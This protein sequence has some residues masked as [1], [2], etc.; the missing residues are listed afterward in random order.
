[1]IV[2]RSVL[3][4]LLLM[5]G[6][7]GVTS[8]AGGDADAESRADSSSPSGRSDG[9]RGA[10][11]AETDASDAT[12]DAGIDAPTHTPEAGVDGSTS[13]PD[14][15]A[16]TGNPG[17]DAVADAVASSDGGT[18][19][20]AADGCAFACGGKCV[21][22]ETDVNN[23]GACGTVCLVLCSRGQCAVVTA[24]SA[25]LGSACGL[26]SG[27]AVECW[28]D[29]YGGALGTGSSTAPD[30]CPDGPCSSTPVA[31]TGVTNATS[32]SLGI[33]SGCALL[34]DGTVDCWGDNVDGQ[35]GSGSTT[36]PDDC[37]GFACGP[38]PA[39]VAG[40]SGVSALSFGGSGGCARLSGGAVQCWGL[41][42]SGELGVG[43][44]TG[45]EAC[46]A[47]ET[48]SPTPVVVPALTGVTT[49]AIGVVSSC[50]L[51]SDGTVECWGSNIF[52]QLGSGTATGPELCGGEPCS[53]TPVP[54]AGLAGVTAVSVGWLSA[55]AV[56]SDGTVDCWGAS[57][58][59]AGPETCS[60]LACSTTPV[61]VSGLSG[62]T[63]VSVG[64][65]SA[66]AV[67]SDGTVDCWGENEFGQ[68]G[69]GGTVTSSSPLPVTGLADVSSVSVGLHFTACAV[70]SGGNVKCWG[71][72][73]F[74]QLGNG[75]ITGPDSCG[76][77]GCSMTPVAVLW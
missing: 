62:V 12:R 75:T 43:D 14:A 27:G 52:G 25:G 35:L 24:V 17:P 1:M 11:A 66:C 16:S 45:P 70:V 65:G 74:G 13:K 46:A 28:G 37:G 10:P 29:N 51:L 63:S 6:C 50:A 67:L 3:A 53:T 76:G 58:G 64:M 68:L 33:S 72:N 61:P 2:K 5:T 60:G 32:V 20:S 19:G 36:G 73:E 69:N 40:L 54:V 23:C 56:L 7:F 55:C 49:V 30:A 57:L 42:G 41:N 9:S 26:V 15:D 34:S 71:D 47:S 8:G 59:N 77:V 44:S 18:D 48:C 39:S 22:P 4:G 38:T 31:V 21:D